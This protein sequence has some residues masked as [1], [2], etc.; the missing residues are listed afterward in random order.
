MADFIAYHSVSRQGNDYSPEENFS[1]Y[2]SKGERFLRSSIDNRVW[3]IVGS[4]EKSSRNRYLLAGMYVP[5]A[6]R[7]EGAGWRITGRG[8]S[9]R[10]REDLTDLPWFAHLRAEQSNFSLGYNRT[11]NAQA[12]EA[13]VA[14]L[15]APAPPHERDLAIDESLADID[16][17][18]TTEGTRVLRHHLALER[19]R[20]LVDAKR[21]YTLRRRGTLA[22]EACSFDFLAIYGERG[23]DFC[24]V[25]HTL[26]LSVGPRVTS[27]RDLAIVCSN[28]HRM[29]HRP[30]LLSVAQLRELLAAR[31]HARD[32]EGDREQG[33]AQQVVEA[34][35]G[36]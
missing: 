8:T 18:D 10:P 24:E 30:P 33:A 11:N 3:V 36:R 32:R 34:A 12:V 28:C 29:L 15:P 5:D 14:M 16:L 4:R 13:L 35:K 6:V 31:A 22:C 23:R 21:A 17:L 2:S 7:P 1:F 9:V 27:L 25:H 26:P 19:N 20:K